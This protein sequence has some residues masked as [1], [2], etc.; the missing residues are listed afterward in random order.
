MTRTEH[1]NIRAVAE[2]LAGEP[3]PGRTTATLLETI[4][5]NIGTM[6]TE[7][8]GTDYTVNS[9]DTDVLNV[10]TSDGPVTVT[11]GSDF[12]RSGATITIS[13]VTNNAATN[14]ITVTSASGLNL[15]GSSNLVIDVDGGAV[16]VEYTES[17]LSGSA[18]FNL[19]GTVGQIL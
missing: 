11:L 7:S 1:D 8:T 2:S 3:L 18:T 10:D 12:E 16:T 13:D 6:V 5:Q 15:N 19:I 4:E 17:L 14:N 9:P